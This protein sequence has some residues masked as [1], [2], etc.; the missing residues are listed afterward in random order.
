MIGRFSGLYQ[1]TILVEPTKAGKPR[2]IQI[3][4]KQR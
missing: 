2:F 4:H 3:I 1:L